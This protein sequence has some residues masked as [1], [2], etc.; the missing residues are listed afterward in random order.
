[1]REASTVA[2]QRIKENFPELPTSVP[3]G[4]NATTT[5]NA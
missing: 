1:M 2:E 4:Q 5:P 3:S